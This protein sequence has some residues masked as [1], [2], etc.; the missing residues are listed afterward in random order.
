MKSEKYPK[1][2]IHESISYS[3]DSC[4]FRSLIDTSSKSGKS[5]TASSSSL[6]R[7]FGS[8]KQELNKSN[9]NKSY[10]LLK[11]NSHREIKTYASDDLLTAKS[12]SMTPN[13]ALND[14]FNLLTEF[15]HIEIISYEEIYYLGI[16]CKKLNGEYADSKGYYKAITGDHLGYRYEIKHLLGSGT[17]GDVYDCYDHK[18][19][20]NVAVKI[21]RNQSLYKDSGHLEN[22]IL[23]ELAKADPEDTN[24]IIK[25]QRSFEFRG[26]L[27]IVF[28]LL[29][30]NLF[31]F[32]HQNEFKGIGVQLVRR[33]AV[34]ILM[35]L[36][37][38]HSVGIIHCDLKPENILLKYENKSSIKVIDFGSACQEGNKIFEYIQSRYYR[39]PEIVIEAAYDKMIDM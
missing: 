20:N 2:S 16:G 26:H 17:F 34:Q 4:Y 9:S 18:R 23:H 10:K 30:L 13:K 8:P 31:Q 32:L 6:N 39:A 33:I 29:S 22:K 11:L 38:V 14:Y 21:I 27:C 3:K 25:K 35:A 37:T 36:K 19:S 7:S 28:E 5:S 15:E 12:T 1:Y 24:C